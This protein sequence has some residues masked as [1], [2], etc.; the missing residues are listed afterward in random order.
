MSSAS[1]PKPRDLPDALK[2]FVRRTAI[3]VRHARFKDDCERLI[4][5]I[6]RALEAAR[7]H[8]LSAPDGVGRVAE[9]AVITTEHRAEVPAVSSAAA[10][11]APTP[12]DTTRKKATKAETFENSLG[13]RFVPVP[14]YEGNGRRG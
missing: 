12:E 3:E 9:T 6:E 4:V 13:M 7:A 10:A 2:S 8:Q 14:I 1:I 5:A 11:P